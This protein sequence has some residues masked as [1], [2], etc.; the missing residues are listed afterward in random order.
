MHLSGKTVAV[1]GASGMI[2]VYLCRSLLKAGARVI[3]VVRNIEKAAFLAEEGVEF[4]KADLMDPD[5]LRNA[6]EGCDSVI[7]NAAM[8]VAAK[9]MSARKEHE[10]ANIEG[11]R[12]VLEAVSS[13]GIN[14]VLH[15][16]TFGVYK[17]SVFRTIDEE[18]PMLNGQKGQGG[19]YRST[20][21]VSEA[22]AWDMAKKHDLALTTF[23]PAGVFGARD[24]NT[25]QPLYKLM[26]IPFLPIP[27]IAFPLVYA[28]DLADVI[29]SAIS[30]EKSFGEA[31]NV[32]GDSEQIY[33]FLKAIVDIL[34]NKPAHL[35]LPLPIHIK[36][37]NSKAEKHLGFKTRS[38]TQAMREIALEESPAK[39][40]I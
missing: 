24:F 25:L 9:S 2:G 18:S 14:R 5:A 19:P 35:Y 16:S 26:G 34:D 31:Y 11:T 8:Y 36:V 7:S 17:W 29:V 23:R 10:N 37:D 27:S 28:A 1:T 13:A 30:N 38:F 40:L 21:Q 3:G 6:F 20:K 39:T 22:L 15:V 32:T 4:R 33:K 12:N